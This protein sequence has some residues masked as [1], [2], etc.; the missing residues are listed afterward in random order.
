[1]FRE[2]INAF[3]P[4]RC[5]DCLCEDTWYCADCRKKA[6]ITVQS[7]IVCKTQRPRGTTC[8]D[9]REE[10]NI[11]GILSAGLY[12]DHA[13]QRGIEWL[14]FKGIANIADILAGLII[15]KL[16]LIASLEELSQRAILVP[17]PLH[18]RKQRDRGFNQSEYIAKSIGTICNIEVANLLTRT[19]STVSQARLPHDMRQQNISGAFQLAYAEQEFQNKISEKNIIILVDDVATTGSTITEAASAFQKSEDMQIWA[20]TVARG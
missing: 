2:I 3:A 8:I 12:A 5:I 19:K 4:A 13:L 18:K 15:P 10:T 17:I 1:M 14:K 16:S 20:V 9:C 6:P 7:C 11:T